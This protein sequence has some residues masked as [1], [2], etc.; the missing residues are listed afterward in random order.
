MSEGLHLPSLS[1]SDQS[2]YEAG[3][4]AIDSAIRATIT[5]NSRIADMTKYESSHQSNEETTTLRHAFDDMEANEPNIIPQMNV[6][7]LDD[8]PSVSSQPPLPLTP[9]KD[10]AAIVESETYSGL[11]RTSPYKEPDTTLSLD[12]EE[13][14]SDLDKSPPSD[15]DQHRTLYNSFESIHANDPMMISARADPDDHNNHDDDDSSNDDSSY[16][17]SHLPEPNS[18]RRYS[19][20]SNASQNSTTQLPNNAN[21]ITNTSPNRRKNIHGRESDASLSLSDDSV[22]NI[23]TKH[24]MPVLFG[25]QQG[26]YSQP[27]NQ[28]YT[29]PYNQGPQQNPYSMQMQPLNVNQFIVPSQRTGVPELY[30]EQIMPRMHSVN[31]LASTSSQNSSSSDTSLPDELQNVVITSSQRRQISRGSSNA[32]NIPSGRRSPILGE[33]PPSRGGGHHLSIPPFGSPSTVNLQP[34]PPMILHSYSA[35]GVSVSGAGDHSGGKNDD[36]TAIQQL[37]HP[38]PHLMTAEQL[39]VWTATAMDGNKNNQ[40]RRIFTGQQPHSTLQQTGGMS[41]FPNISGSRGESDFIYSGDSDS[42]IHHHH[43]QQQNQ[44]PSSKHAFG[45]PIRGT[46][47]PIMINDGQSL[48]SLSWEQPLNHGRPMKVGGDGDEVDPESM[49]NNSY[50]DRGFK[51]YWQR[52]IMLMYMSILNLLSDWTCYSVAPIALLT[53]EAFGEIN[54]EQLVVVFLIANGFATAC[55][56]IILSRLGLRRTVLFGS[57]L[58]MIGSIVKSGGMPP[59]I[60]ADLKKGEGEWR[61]YLGFFLVGLSQP[62][63]QCT[64]ALLSASWFPEAERTLAT[65]VALNSNQLGIG[66]AFIFGTMLVETSDDIPKYF[67]LLSILS[68]LTFLGTLVQFDDAPPTPPSDTAKVMHGT[69]E[70]KLPTVQAIFESVRNIGGPSN[71]FDAGKQE[72]SRKNTLRKEK[73]RNRTEKYQRHISEE[74][75]T[76]SIKTEENEKRKVSDAQRRSSR[77]TSTSER[78]SSRRV[79]ASGSNIARRRVSKKENIVNTNAESGFH[80]VVPSPSPAL[81]G[82]I[83]QE[84][85]ETNSNDQDHDARTPLMPGHEFPH[86]DQQLSHDQDT[87]ARYYQQPPYLVPG[88]P[89]HPGELY[90]NYPMYPPQYQYPYRDPQYAQFA[91]YQQ[92]QLPQYQFPQLP[93]PDPYM[94]Y[95][96]SYPYQPHPFASYEPLER[97]LPATE[98]IDEGAEPVITILPHHLDI[99]IRD[100]QIWLSTRACLARPGFIH[101]LVSFTVSGVVINTLST[102]MDYLVRLNG[103]GREYTGIVGGTFQFVIM[104]SSLIIG[105]VCDRTRAYY[106]ITIGM[107]VLG[108]FG[109][110]ECGVS[111]DSNSGVSLRWSLIIVALLVGP[112]Q[113]VSTELG[114]DVVYPLSEN[115]VLVIQQLFSN[116]LSAAFIPC[117]KAMKDVGEGTLYDR[118]TE[119]PSYTFSFYLLI[120]LHACATVFFATFNGRYLRYEHE[121]EKQAQEKR[122]KALQQRSQLVP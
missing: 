47:H 16:F 80:A 68:T 44:Q 53:E 111:L 40:D 14:V 81:W 72:T 76:S 73:G 37:P 56:P 102:F 84:F 64:P 100:D 55:E 8:T 30:P 54:A 118:T 65:G 63:Y 70:A 88:Y 120:V 78:R 67:G 95:Q 38:Q 11:A 121:L 108:A 110:A 114:V 74:S 35:N 29:H 89:G 3:E 24:Q 28:F 15:H 34:S 58:L 66:F 112:L 85:D 117:F 94:S 12:K 62:L 18:G 22:E 1:T 99:H 23:G 71:P 87:S 93:L 6:Y 57:L 42:N 86:H 48:R 82:T 52:W 39:A 98:A 104:I 116:L 51:V 60:Q 46:N 2:S 20:A 109:L 50:N 119:R 4:E 107:L 10:I 43:Q 5:N 122:R 31:S 106:S 83:R 105:K 61:V 36:M 59:I 69:L 32:S 13:P 115:T 96:H 103:A 33:H 101:S 9:V 113:P 45:E 41:N 91:Y 19:W 27:P 79:T 97:L 92:T 7:V 90:S 17:A 77:R 75:K 25:P 26:H 21:T 49:K